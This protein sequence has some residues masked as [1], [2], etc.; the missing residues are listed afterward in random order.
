MAQPAVPSAA[1]ATLDSVLSQSLCGMRSMQRPA[2]CCCGRELCVYLEHNNAAMDGLEKDLQS[3]AQIGQALL[4]RHEAYMAEA[5]EERRKMGVS[6]DKL[7]KDK[8]ELEAANARTI[9]ENRYL[10]D[11]LEEMNGTISNADAQILS[12]NTTLE[13]TRKQ[14]ERLTV[15]AA[16]TSQLE[17]QLAAMEREQN[18]LHNQLTSTEDLER[19][20]LQ[21]WKGA[22]RIIRTLHAQVDCIERA[23]REERARHAE[24]VARF[25]RRRAVERELENAAG[26]LKGAA[27]A[28]TL[29]RYG[30]NSVV[31]HFVRDI[32]Q[33]NANLQLGIVELREMLIG[34][35][36]EVENLRE[37]MLL[38]RPVT[39][40]PGVHSAGEDL[41]SELSGA[42][43]TETK[44]DF[45]LHH[46]YHAAPVAKVA[47]ERSLVGRLKKRR[48]I[49]SPGARTPSSGP[50]T[51]RRTPSS[52]NMGPMPAS[53]AATILSQTSVS[54]PPPSQPS[55]SHRWS[56]RSLQAPSSTAAS[57]LPSSPCSPFHDM[58]LFDRMDDTMDSSRPT[59]PGSTS[60]GSPYLYPRCPKRDSDVSMT[61]FSPHGSSNA[62]QSISG[63]LGA[64]DLDFKDDYMNNPT[65][66]LL[67]HSTI[68]EEPEDDIATRP[69][70][71]DPNPDHNVGD[72]HTPM[73]PMR[74]RLHRTT[75][76]ESM[77]SS[78]GVDI[79]KLRTKGSQ[80]LGGHGFTLR[81]SLGASTASAGPV[82]SSTEAVAYRSRTRGYNTSDYNRLLLGTS[83]T[84][85]SDTTGSEKSTFGKRMG[86]WMFG[87][88]GVAPTTSTNCLKAKDA[89][90]AVD[91]GADGKQAGSMHGKKVENRLSTHVE[92]VSFD[93]TL[94]QES[95]GE[96]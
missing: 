23:A 71:K 3:A 19:T 70:T 40:R 39:A 13:S 90:S 17:E 31:S 37:Q 44:P 41:N 8:K 61:S 54:I 47:R 86:G 52:N 6:I 45:H 53:S 14:L 85:S 21:R 34:S 29:E 65:F 11:Q 48:N 16:Q 63:V 2:T 66:P 46:H 92:V 1:S 56:Q 89:L 20:A 15:L 12:L 95:L 55:H 57:S 77:L 81:S 64:A 68:L 80:Y 58:S 24:V 72:T 49:T 87:K 75:S 33:D 73:Q 74:P 94:L 25:E 93:N 28:T 9:E 43:P 84:T 79:P 67:E 91:K 32:L 35:N 18:E 76:H 51:P 83:P 60:L 50:T 10:L 62:P 27:A 36:E 88:W 26:R 22:E 59:T 78:R 30:S 42:P 69:S 4:S 96:G 38:H 7:G 5:E 82:T